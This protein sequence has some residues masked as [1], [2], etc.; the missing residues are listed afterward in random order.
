MTVNKAIHQT[1][2]VL[3]LLISL[4]ANAPAVAQETGF[5]KDYSQLEMKK[6]PKGVERNIWISPKLTPK[7]YQKIIIEPITFFPAPQPTEQVSMEALDEIRAY[8]DAGVRK[9]VEASIPVV[10]AAAPG[11]IRFRWAITAASVD[12]SLK[13]YQLVPLALVV[14]AAKRGTGTASYDVKL[15]VEGEWIDSVSG[16]VL[17]RAVRVGKGVEVKG[18]APLTLKVAQPQLDS[19]MAAIKEDVAR[20]SPPQK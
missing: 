19:W 1:S 7:N 3:V 4:V 10:S 14:T 12:K 6:D 18:N 16:E 17:M 2:L 11:V 8:I 20:M 13:A 9:A 15:M 5:L